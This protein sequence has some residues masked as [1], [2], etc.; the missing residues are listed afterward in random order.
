MRINEGAILIPKEVLDK[1]SNIVNRLPNLLISELEEEFQI[2]Y[3]QSIMR[4]IETISKDELAL[5]KMTKP[6]VLDTDILKKL[7]NLNRY[8]L[9]D[10]PKIIIIK[11]E[12]RVNLNRLNEVRMADFINI[13]SDR[14]EIFH[15]GVP[16]R[17]N[18]FN[19]LYLKFRNSMIQSIINSIP[20]VYDMEKFS[21]TVKSEMN[22]DVGIY[23]NSIE[24]TSEL[25]I[26]VEGGMYKW[27]DTED[28]K[29]QFQKAYDFYGAKNDR[30]AKNIIQRDTKISDE[31]IQLNMANFTSFINGLQHEL[32]QDKMIGI[33]AHEYVHE[34]Q[35]DR[36]FKN[37][38]TTSDL[39]Y[40]SPTT[41][42]PDTM[43][44][45][46]TKKV[47]PPEFEELEET[48]EHMLSNAM[49]LGN[50][51]EVMSNAK[52]IAMDVYRKVKLV[53][54][55]D[56]KV[57]NVMNQVEVVIG[58]ILREISSMKDINTRYFIY[59]HLFKD[60]DKYYL[61]TNDKDEGKTF[62][63]I[64][65]GRTT[66]RMLNDYITQYLKHLLEQEI[67]Q[68]KKVNENYVLN[69][70]LILI[71]NEYINKINYF[72]DN[73][74]NITKKYLQ[75]TDHHRLIGE[76]IDILYDVVDNPSH[77]DFTRE[78]DIYVKNTAQRLNMH[79]I[80]LKNDPFIRIVQSDY[81]DIDKTNLKFEDCIFF[82]EN[83]LDLTVKY[84]NFEMLEYIVNVFNKDIMN[85]LLL[86]KIEIYDI[87]LIANLFT[88]ID[89]DLG[90]SI[91]FKNSEY[92]K[93]HDIEYIFGGS[94]RN[95]V[96]TLDCNNFNSLVSAIKRNTYRDRISSV[97]QHELVHY[98][99]DIRSKGSFDKEI[100]I[101]PNNTNDRYKKTKY[102]IYNADVDAN[103]PNVER[104]IKYGLYLG[105]KIE[106][107]ANAKS[108]VAEIIN[109]IIDERKMSQEDI[110]GYIE[111]IKETVNNIDQLSDYSETFR[112]YHNYFKE[113]VKYRFINTNQDDKRSTLTI[114]GGKILKKLLSYVHEDIMRIIQDLE[115]KLTSNNGSRNWFKELK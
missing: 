38:K 14:I 82:D 51:N 76:Y 108:I 107:S 23:F 96:I 17:M 54:S 5:T 13:Y 86:Y 88:D 44:L 59:Y 36:V 91:K 12:K 21:Q 81:L 18:T 53:V 37:N 15:G 114:T 30:F 69:E 64:V 78:I 73:F 47:V 26:A 83:S 100:Y 90:F 93:R 32:I 101:T 98:F 29:A 25:D 92:E 67:R 103:D 112:R 106:I 39:F 89:S 52:Q 85:K 65:D 66:L 33:F 79:L 35:D 48:Y 19:F 77:Y 57:K 60:N 8:Y 7:L 61:I 27:R 62:T 56:S 104:D 63:K 105:N 28:K 10:Y 45:K 24:D 6:K 2:L 111:D 80:Y 95:K 70:G 42:D 22:L 84:Y 99:Q 40:Y 87:T 16:N 58:R 74:L 97:I 11:D 31:T 34:L 75:I 46:S 41:H 68:N 20:K 109:K 113:N 1:F 43:K 9:I 50:Q 72:L 49:Y 102:K 4:I 3:V 110:Q 94:Y 115:L 71:P 55:S